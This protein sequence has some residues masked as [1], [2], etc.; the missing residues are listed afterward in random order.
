MAKKRT[1]KQ[2]S[3]L[4][5]KIHPCG[6]CGHAYGYCS[7]AYDGKPV[8]CRCEVDV[9]VMK[10]CSQVGCNEWIGRAEPAPEIVHEVLSRNKFSDKIPEK[11][12]PIFE[13]G[14]SYPVRFIKV[15]DIPPQGISYDGKA[16]SL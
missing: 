7:P 5:V 10:L 12:V 14:N 11:V 6:E 1:D 9:A 16:L 3:A 13:K 15:S 4:P 2:D 8:L